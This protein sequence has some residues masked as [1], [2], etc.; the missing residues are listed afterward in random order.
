MDQ[1]IQLPRLSALHRRLRQEGSEDFELLT[2]TIVLA[3]T[4]WAFSQAPQIESVVAV[5]SSIPVPD[6][7]Q[8]RLC[9]LPPLDFDS[10]RIYIF[11]NRHHMNRIILCL[12]LL[13]LCNLVP[14]LNKPFAT[15]DVQSSL[16]SSAQFITRCIPYALRPSSGSSRGPPWN[17]LRIFA[18]LTLAYGA[19]K[20]LEGREPGLN[21]DATTMKEYCGWGFQQMASSWCWN[22]TLETLLGYCEAWSGGETMPL[23]SKKKS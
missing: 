19:W 13:K 14:D 20:Y 12:N 15:D 2:Q 9:P 22:V 23:M 10:I 11:A 21:V 7:S 16:V 6:P 18:P 1:T 4:L 17:A 5:H 8:D 3:S